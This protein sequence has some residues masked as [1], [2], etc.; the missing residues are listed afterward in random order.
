[1]R[2]RQDSSTLD[3][4]RDLGHLRMPV[5]TEQPDGKRAVRDLDG[6]FGL[7]EVG[8]TVGVAG[9]AASTGPN[10]RIRHLSYGIPLRTFCRLRFNNPLKSRAGTSLLGGTSCKR[11]QGNRIFDRD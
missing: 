7:G 3:L 5:V 11:A 4:P 6:Q 8:W 9:L 1:M 10:S 2:D